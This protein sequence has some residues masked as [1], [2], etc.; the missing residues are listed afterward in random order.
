MTKCAVRLFLRQRCSVRDGVARINCIEV[1][2]DNRMIA[3]NI[4]EESGG[5]WRMALHHA[6]PCM[7]GAED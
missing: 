5:R 1:I 2:G 6:G 4:F 3:T 7:M